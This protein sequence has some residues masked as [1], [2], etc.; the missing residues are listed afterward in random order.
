MR[1]HIRGTRWRHAAARVGAVAVLAGGGIAGA[2]HGG[3]IS[4]IL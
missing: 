4:G 2:L 3:G 1:E